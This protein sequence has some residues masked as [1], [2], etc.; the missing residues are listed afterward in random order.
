M[1]PLS[2]LN[3]PAFVEVSNFAGDLDWQRRWV[4]TGDAPYPA[5]TLDRSS[6]ERFTPNAIW[7]N[8]AHPS[9]H[10]TRLH[11]APLRLF[12]MTGR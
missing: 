10:D 7:A 9:N 6:P 5:D 1:L 2:R 3:V 12:K 8:N 11:A 4:K